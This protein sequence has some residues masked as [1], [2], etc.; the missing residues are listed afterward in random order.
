MTG[1]GTVVSVS[2]NLATVLIRKTSACSHD[3]SECST[4]TAPEYKMEVLNPIG[5]KLGD[6]V[7]IEAKSSKVLFIALCVYILPVFLMLFAAVLCD[8]MSFSSI[9]T[10]VLFAFMILLWVLVIKKAN[11]KLKL[12]NVIVSTLKE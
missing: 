9:S 6:K 11:H 4:C 1:Q 2:D 12:Q 8:V 3:C 7:V 5:A 10:I